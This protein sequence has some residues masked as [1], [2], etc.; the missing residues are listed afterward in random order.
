[1]GGPP[2]HLPKKFKKKQKQ[3]KEEKLP[4]LQGIEKSLEQ[5]EEGGRGW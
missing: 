3:K 4:H 1:M 5:K 2:P